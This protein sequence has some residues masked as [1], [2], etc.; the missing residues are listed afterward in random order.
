[1]DRQPLCYESPYQPT[2][3]PL[4]ARRGTSLRGDS[5]RRD[6][7]PSRLI[8]HLQFE[9]SGWKAIVVLVLVAGLTISF[10]STWAWYAY[11][12]SLSHQAVA[13]SLAEVKSILGTTLERDSDL[14]AT[15]NAVVATHPQIT[16]AELA[17]ILSKLDLSQRYPGSFAFTYVENVGRPKLQEFE[18]IAARDPP[19]GVTVADPAVVRASLNGRSGYCLTRL[20]AVE[21]LGEGILKNVLL[22]WISPYISAH[23]NFCASSFVSLFDTSAKTGASVASSLVSLI[24]PAPGLPDIPETLHSLLLRLPIFLELSP[25]YSGTRVPTTT[26][27]RARALAGWTMAVFD[28]DQILS[29]ALVGD[30]TASL[31]LAYVPPG[32]KQA[33]LARA[34]RPQPGAATKTLTFPADPGWVVHAAVT[35]RD[36]GPS[37]AIQALA[38]FLGALALTMLLVV[39]LSLLIRSRRSA[40]EL[41]EERT[42]E[43]RH[44][45]LHDSLTGLPNR[46]L[47]NQRAH[48]LVNRARSGGL[49]VAVFFIDLDDFKKVNDTLGHDAGDGLLQAVAARLSESVR[50]SDTVGRLGGDEFVVLSENSFSG[51]GLGVVAERLLAVLREPFRLGD[52]TRTTLST[53]ASIGIA[54]G[55]GSSP[56]EL[57][58]NADIAMYRA[59]SMGKNCHV[60]FEPEMHEVVKKQLTME[61]D[62]ARALAN[63]EFYL[64]Y[65]PIVDL[66]TG[67]PRD[68]EALLRWRHP[69][70]GVVGPVE[71][72]SVLE[73]SDLIIDV[74][75]F[76]LMEACRSVK[77]WHDRGSS[78]GVSV[79]VGARQLHH[80][81]LVDHVREALEAAALDPKFL[82]VEVTESMLMIDPKVTAQRLEALS[83]IGVRIAIDDFG[84]GY[85]SLS[86]L[87]EFPADILKI[88]RSFVAQL[89]TSTGTTFLDALI[90]LGKS[91]GLVT[92]AEGI[93]QVSQLSHLKAKGCDWGQGFLFSEPLPA[94]EVEQLIRSLRYDM[95]GSL[96]SSV[97]AP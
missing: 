29:P 85:A 21:I 13:S 47:V 45:A 83:N 79:N 87:R 44:Q 96:S 64:V 7:G 36:N 56:E 11:T 26:R 59:K 1:M 27:T 34:G 91:L 50:S 86:Y 54:T 32:G 95:A 31:V 89:A 97:T 2:E 25:V 92:I 73:S 35:G 68:V 38:V 43:L 48:D 49:P 22:A 4:S 80:D 23:F 81:V 10:A 75:R 53:S 62:L 8:F 70:R 16:N 51:G 66:E 33:V 58:R 12:S 14:L 67:M 6:S 72:I 37:P 71:F 55:M 74:G 28:A 61:T 39:L 9:H 84:T 40:L 3:P 24:R 93:E 65:Q 78:V 82:T 76:V 46:F 18:A 88:D 90:Q 30:K 5:G 15:V 69:Q 19:L 20:V 52:A 77:A 41:V 42:A 57:L 63:R 94:E 60:L 17:A